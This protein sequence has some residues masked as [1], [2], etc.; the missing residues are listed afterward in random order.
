MT[1]LSQLRTCWG[2]LRN[3]KWLWGDLNGDGGWNVLD[4]VEL[5]NCVIADNCSNC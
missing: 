2:L 1:H 5:A 4:I 3:R